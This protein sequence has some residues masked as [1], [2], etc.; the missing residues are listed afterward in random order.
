MNV[1]QFVSIS[2]NFLEGK[3]YLITIYNVITS[4]KFAGFQLTDS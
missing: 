2:I 1:T 4:L 3:Q